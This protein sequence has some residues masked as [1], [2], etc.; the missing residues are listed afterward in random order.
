MLSLLVD[1]VTCSYG[2]AVLPALPLILI[3]EQASSDVQDLVQYRHAALKLLQ[4]G[5]H[6][7]V[8][9]Q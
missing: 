7:D 5:M 3:D 8:N 4:S 2:G 1:A 6:S 9:A